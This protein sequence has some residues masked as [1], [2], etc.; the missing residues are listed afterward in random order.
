MSLA[1][2]K[3]CLEYPPFPLSY[4]YH[5]ILIKLCH[6]P[7]SDLD[8]AWSVLDVMKSSGLEPTADSYAALLVAHSEAGDA[9]GLHRTFKECEAAELTLHDRDLLESVFTLAVHDHLSLIPQV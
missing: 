9:E 4:L 1:A 6:I 7:L 3:F 8:S 5:L 2:H